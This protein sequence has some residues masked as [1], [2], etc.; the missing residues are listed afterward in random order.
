MYSLLIQ[1]NLY[2]RQPRICTLY[3]EI[4]RK[5]DAFLLVRLNH[6]FLP[7]ISDLLITHNNSSLISVF[8]EK[9]DDLSLLSII[10][11]LKSHLL[12][13]LVLQK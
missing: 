1:V 5:A 4:Y 10:D 8:I 7:V 3:E 2:I 6:V 13:N 11:M 12:Y 9:A